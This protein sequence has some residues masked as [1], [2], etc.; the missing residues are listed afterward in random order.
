MTPLMQ[1]NFWLSVIN[2]FLLIYL[3]IVHVRMTYNVRSSFTFGLLMFIL[4][5]LVHN[6]LAAYFYLAMKEFYAA[7]TELPV[8]IITLMET[9]AFSIFTWISRN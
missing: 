7:G 4:V 2:V 1:I 5:F 6:I 9:I 3:A 8:L